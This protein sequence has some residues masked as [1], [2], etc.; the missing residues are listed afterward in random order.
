MLIWNKKLIRDGFSTILVFI[1]I[2]FKDHEYFLPW[3]NHSDL[4][5]ETIGECLEIIALVAL[6]LLPRVLG[7]EGDNLKPYSLTFR[8][9]ILLAGLFAV[10]LLT[11]FW[12]D[13]FPNDQFH[14]SAGLM[15]FLYARLGGL[16]LVAIGYLLEP[17]H[18]KP[19]KEQEEF[20]A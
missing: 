5:F 19:I 2:A 14:S 6:F 16:G 9:R 17:K 11:S 13:F 8:L 10:Y 15:D 7:I 1:A 3:A 18:A 4:R 20:L 12:R